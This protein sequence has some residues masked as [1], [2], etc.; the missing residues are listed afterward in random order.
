MALRAAR[1]GPRGAEARGTVL[2]LHGRT[3][4]LEKYAQTAAAWAR[5]GFVAWSLDWRGQGGSARALADARKGH[6][7]GFGEYQRDVRALADAAAD[8]PGPHLMQA[9][10]M[11]GLIGLR[12][13]VDGAAP[14]TAAIF[15]A[16]MWGLALPR[17]REL[18]ARLLS[19]AACALG[20]GERYVPG[21]G[22]PTPYALQGFEDNLL[23]SDADGYERIARLVREGGSHALGGPTFGWLRAAFDEMDALAPARLAT[24]ALILLGDAEAVVSPGAIRARAARDGAA[25]VGLPGARHEPLFET[26]ET[27][28]AV[29]EAIDGFLETRGL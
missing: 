5:R 11:G 23:T 21:G 10:S 4:F 28:A 22:G 17:E 1:L 2:I 29:W 14:S 3:E 27:L 20:F 15:T 19:A 25:L 9:H 12:A 13:L 26:P 8:E 16:P 18:A 7:G 24:P 6:V